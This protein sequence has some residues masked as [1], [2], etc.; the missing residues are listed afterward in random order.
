MLREDNLEALQIGLEEDQLVKTYQEAFQLTRELGFQY[1]WIDALC[2][3][4]GNKDDW[5]HESQKMGEVYGNAALTIVA[6]RADDSRNGFLQNNF[7]P[8][9]DPYP[10]AYGRLDHS[11]NEITGLHVG[12]DREWFEETMKPDPVRT[13][14]WCL[15]EAELSRRQLVF[16]SSGVSFQ[17]KQTNIFEDQIYKFYHKRDVLPKGVAAFSTGG[18][19]FPD[20][21]ECLNHWYAEFLPDY[22]SRLLTNRND[23]FAAITAL[24]KMA[25]LTVNGRYLAGLWES[26]LPRGLLWMPR[27]NT[28]WKVGPSKAEPN[29]SPLQRL[30]KSQAP[31][32]SW[33]SV[34]G[35]VQHG[36]DNKKR[37]PPYPYKSREGEFLVRPA[38]EDDTSWT[39]QKDCDADVLYMPRCELKMHGRP[40]KLRCIG[41]T[42]EKFMVWWDTEGRRI[43]QRPDDLPPRA[44]DAILFESVVSLRLEDREI[45]NSWF[46][47]IVAF[48]VFDVAGER[49]EEFWALPCTN[50][51]GLILGRNDDGTL[52]RLG[53]FHIT[54]LA[55]FQAGEEELIRLI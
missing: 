48:G 11:G 20:R 27:Y 15:Q 49:V 37:W 26:D 41:I 28:R 55:W 22:T 51:L 24:A 38:S 4:Q 10:F 9:A 29:L 36:W 14:G 32:W 33:A 23:I 18:R 25:Q 40:R 52:H 8:V 2:I 6:A 17:C 31:S 5:E 16:G 53:V 35:P 3:I 46:D 43:R 19:D 34:Q 42:Q 30:S 44:K 45:S 47:Q 39:E 50:A 54:N 12:L 7:R 21:L 13:R 1:I